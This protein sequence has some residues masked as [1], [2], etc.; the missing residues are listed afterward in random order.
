MRKPE[1]LKI[2]FRAAPAVLAVAALLCCTAPASAD[3]M[4]S[5]NSQTGVQ[6]TFAVSNSDLIEAGQPTLLSSVLTSGTEM[7]SSSVTK[8]NDGVAYGVD[9]NYYDTT[10]TLTPSN[11]TVVTVTLD[12]TTNTLGYDIDTI[13]SLTGNGLWNGFSRTSQKYDVSYSTVS[14]P[15]TWVY[16]SGDAGATVD[17]LADTAEEEQVIIS[18]GSAAPIATGVKSLQFTFYDKGASGYEQNEYREIDVVGTATVPEPSTIVLLAL[19]GLS[20][21]WFKRNK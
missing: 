17:R 18:S 14:D 19:A 15:S 11:A 10:T 7:F 16:L 5:V 2:L 21:A 6:N 13:V 8:I 3:V 20:L 12:T 9:N 4:V 1:V